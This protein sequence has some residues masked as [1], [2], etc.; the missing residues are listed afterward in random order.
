M[1]MKG[2]KG[3]DGRREEKVE[4][5]I[6]RGLGRRK[7]VGG[8]MGDSQHIRFSIIVFS[9]F[10]TNIHLMHTLYFR[11]AVGWGIETECT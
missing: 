6:G 4:E 8:R 2:V 7:G 5:W 11:Q 3:K 1:L 10:P 9:Y